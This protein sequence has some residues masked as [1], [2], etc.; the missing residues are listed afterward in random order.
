MIWKEDSNPWSPDWSNAVFPLEERDQRWA[1][2]RGL[3]RRDSID[4][5]ICL[6]STHNYDR[7][8]ADSRYLS[9]LGENADETTLAFPIEGAP[10]AWLS[11]GG[12]WPGSN[13]LADIRA[14]ERGGGGANI[15]RWLDENPR[16][17]TAT[18]AIAGLTASHLS[19]MRS[20]EGEV[21]WGSVELLRQ[22]F[23][24]A[25]FVSATPILGEARW[26]KSAAEI[27]F[28]HEGTAIAETVLG[29][30]AAHAREGV[31]ERALFAEMMYA[32]AKAGGTFPAQIGWC[33]GPQ[34]KVHH[35]LAQPSF[36]TLKRGDAMLH[37]IEGRWGG[38]IAQIDQT[39]VVGDPLP[40]MSEAFKLTIEA[41]DRVFAALKPGVTIGE[42]IAAS[43]VTGM[44]G[45][46]ETSLGFHGRGTGNDG[47]LLVAFRPEPKDVLD[48]VVEEGCCFIIKPSAKVDD[49]G[50]Y[51]RWG[52]SVVVTASGA[53]R[54]GTR[55]KELILLP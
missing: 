30:L 3:M 22:K 35:R 13:W 33:S 9:Q 7:G 28:L 40:Q 23:P 6:P 4:L 21:M 55:P 20:A 49:I 11:R 54:L 41:F 29:A 8:Q 50:D 12:V 39:L 27:D 45:R 36:R 48:I 10:T 14:G 26:R 32:N 43:H 18:I 5:V 47:P 52:E 16:F 46:I 31:S 53:E 38:Y 42:L 51:A 25:R 37:E 19:H 24:R 2:V 17:Q 15:A 34:G 44:G 1:K